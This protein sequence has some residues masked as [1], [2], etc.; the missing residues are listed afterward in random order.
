MVLWYTQRMLADRQLS[1]LCTLTADGVSLRGR[2][3]QELIN[4]LLIKNVRRIF[5]II[6][7]K[8]KASIGY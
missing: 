3:E 8:L 4:G 6:N 5:I 7:T 2:V 1:K